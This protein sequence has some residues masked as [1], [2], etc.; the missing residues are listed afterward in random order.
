MYGS[1][2]GLK[3]RPSPELGTLAL[4]DWRPEMKTPKNLEV[5]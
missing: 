2:I 5:E 1:A 4:A 3:S